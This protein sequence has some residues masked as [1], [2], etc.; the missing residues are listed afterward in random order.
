MA[1]RE[2]ERRGSVG[3]IFIGDTQV[4]MEQKGYYAAHA[5]A[6]QLDAFRWDDSVRVIVITGQEDGQF[7]RLNRRSHWDDPKYKDRLNP[8]KNAS[9]GGINIGGGHIPSAQETLLNI[10][11]PVIARLNGDAIGFGSSILWLCD[12]V[13][14]KD[15]AIVAWGF[16]GMGELLDSEGQKRGMP[17]AMTPTYG[18]YS[19]P[20]MSPPLMKE[21]IMLSKSYT[22]KEL[23]DMKLFNFA[24][25][26]DEVD[27]FVER[28]ANGFVARPASVL[29]R[30][31]RIV[32]KHLAEQYVRVE[33]LAEAYSHLDLWEQAASGSMD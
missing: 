27:A 25:P 31:K 6:E 24:G 28:A 23:A 19:F 4:E 2:P 18:T 1:L 21:F 33:D 30:T 7:Y 14:A 26:M 13:A 8:I 11:K 9:S 5:A 12:I 32:N 3:W 29:A 22:G 16:Q 15:D 17:W 20:L 10:E